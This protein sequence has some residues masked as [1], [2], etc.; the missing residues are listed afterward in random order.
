ME[1]NPDAAG[2]ITTIRYRAAV[3]ANAQIAAADL[4]FA[5]FTQGAPLGARVSRTE[6]ARGAHWAQQCYALLRD[7]RILLGS[8]GPFEHVH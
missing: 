8:S 5:A 3:A 2:G 4:D 1:V 7:A 6:T